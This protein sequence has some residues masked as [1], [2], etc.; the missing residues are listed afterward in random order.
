MPEPNY[1][2]ASF[3]DEDEARRQQDALSTIRSSCSSANEEDRI[4]EVANDS[5][6]EPG[7]AFHYGHLLSS[8][9]AIVHFMKLNYS[10]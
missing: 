9:L 4:E 1:T 8:C 2:Q 10:G 6:I 7:F 5:I 3:D